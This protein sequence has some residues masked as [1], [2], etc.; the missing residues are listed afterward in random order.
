ML[1][2]R[3]SFVRYGGGRGCGVE[4]WCRCGGLF[5]M[6]GLGVLWVVLSYVWLRRGDG[7]MLMRG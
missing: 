3:W 4:W 6:V 7:R 5:D 2:L 1:Y